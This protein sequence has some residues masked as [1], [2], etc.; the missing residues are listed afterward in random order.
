MLAESSFE[1]LHSGPYLQGRESGL[2]R[3][4]EDAVALLDQVE[5]AFGG[6]EAFLADI[7]CQDAFQRSDE[8]RRFL[9]RDSVQ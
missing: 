9:I 3:L 5:L 6:V 4:V 8:L 7:L 1:A 2:A